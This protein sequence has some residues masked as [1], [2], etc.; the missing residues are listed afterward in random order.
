MLTIN[1][2]AHSN[3]LSYSFCIKAIAL[4]LKKLQNKCQPGLQSHVKS[5]LRKC[6]LP[7][8]CDC[9]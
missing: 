2:I 7:S 1:F 9:W 4:G 8:T 6:P 5:Q 3:M